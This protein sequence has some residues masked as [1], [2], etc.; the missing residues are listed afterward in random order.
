MDTKVT[1]ITKTRIRNV[2][3]HLRKAD[4]LARRGS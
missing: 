3:I 2:K 4:A 1:K